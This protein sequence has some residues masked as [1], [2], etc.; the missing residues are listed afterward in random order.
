MM[1][2]LENGKKYVVGMHLFD[3]TLR[4]VGA[5]DTIFDLGF[6]RRSGKA[7]GSNATD[8]ALTELA[9]SWAGL[10]GPFGG[11]GD[12]RIEL[13]TAF[14]ARP[15]E[16]VFSWETGRLSILSHGRAPFKLDRDSVIAVEVLKTV[17]DLLAASASPEV[18]SDWKKAS[19]FTDLPPFEILDRDMASVGPTDRD[20]AAWYAEKLEIPADIF[21]NGAILAHARH[22]QWVMGSGGQEATVERRNPYTW[23]DATEADVESA[24][25]SMPADCPETREQIMANGIAHAIADARQRLVFGNPPWERTLTVAPG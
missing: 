12:I 25:A 19:S 10:C 6:D 21:V 23:T 9:G 8:V 13:G 24:L 15:G 17:G 2:L 4:H 7:A 20:I 18:A 16:M 14:G 1:P 3:V 22:L 11:L 5:G